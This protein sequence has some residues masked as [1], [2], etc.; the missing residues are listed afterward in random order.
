[1]PTELI[2][3][4]LDSEFRKE[5][6]RHL[7][8]AGFHSRTEFIRTAMREKLEEIRMKQALMRFDRLQGRMPRTSD[9]ERRKVRDK[10]GKS[11][12]KEFG[13]E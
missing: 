13:L 9:A 12:L 3:L 11:I 7:K 4:K 6:D 5:M 8:Q 2:T 1:M 10:V